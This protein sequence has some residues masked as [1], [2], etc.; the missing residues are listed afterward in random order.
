[1]KNIRKSGKDNASLMS[2]RK[3]GQWFEGGFGDN[4]SLKPLQM[5]EDSARSENTQDIHPE[6]RFLRWNKYNYIKK[7]KNNEY[8]LF[9]CSTNNHMYMVREIKELIE[10]NI[11]TVEQIESIH[12]QLYDFLK[13]KQFIVDDNFNEVRDA[14]RRMKQDLNSADYYELFIN[15]TLDCNLRCWYCYETLKQNSCVDNRVL[16]S[17]MTFIRNKV[18]SRTL[19]EIQIS[20]FGGEPLLRYNGVIWPIIQFTKKICVEN[21]KK[22]YFNFTTNGV[23]LTKKIV[24]QLY[25]I[26]ANCVFQVPF[27]GNKEYHDR[28]KKYRNGKGTFDKVLENV[29]YALSKGFK[30]TI[31]CNYT[32]ENLHSFDELISIF[33]KYAAECIDYGLLVFT[34]HKIWQA[35]RTV[36]MGQIVGRYKAK[37]TSLDMS[38]YRCYADRENSAVIN[39]N[40]DVYNCTARDFNPQEREGY[41]NEKGEII[42]NKKHHERM[43]IRFSGK[44]CLNCMIF[45]ICNLCSQN[46]LALQ[47]TYKQCP[48][49]YSEQDKEK[50]LL[51]KIETDIISGM[52]S[53]GTP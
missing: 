27:D 6:S 9:N 3:T 37:A 23:L 20:F 26:G 31:R 40:G 8:L 32:S 16:Q 12:P 15:P 7:N 35:D 10:S 30:F 52:D 11:D 45:P 47:G 21:N 38:F 2:G 28:T 17:I 1:M 24:D 51:K 36:Q 44:E 39:Y 48:R 42:Y 14:I 4:E 5:H 29:M 25:T 19:K 43:K 34:Y 49:F 13:Q 46:K 18:E 50:V 33:T 41:L 22:C 53:K